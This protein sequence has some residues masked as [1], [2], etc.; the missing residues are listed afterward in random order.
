MCFHKRFYRPSLTRPDLPGAFPNNDF[1]A[2]VGRGYLMPVFSE[3]LLP[4]LTRQ[5][6]TSPVLRN[7]FIASVSPT[8]NYRHRYLRR[9][10]VRIICTGFIA[11]VSYNLFYR[12][13][14]MKRF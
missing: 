6:L 5:A 13:Y 4:P 11:C 3:T 2:C 14:Y 8:R 9:F 12:P 7:A 1:T 10:F